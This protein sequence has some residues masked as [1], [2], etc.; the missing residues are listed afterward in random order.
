MSTKT[1]Y[2]L[3]G[4]CGIIALIAT[5]AIY[6]TTDPS[7]NRSLLTN[8]LSWVVGLTSIVLVYAVYL[9]CRESASAISMLALA[10]AVIGNG[11]FLFGTFSPSLYSIGD[12]GENIVLMVSVP[13]FGIGFFMTK[14]MSRILAGIA[15][16]TGI[17]GLA[18]FAVLKMDVGSWS[19]PNNPA[20]L[21]AIM[22]TYLGFVL[23]YVIWMAWTG[24]ALLKAS[25]S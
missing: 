7:G 11:L 2:R 12:I 10:A 19:A 8:L 14:G 9:R 23:C 21:P 18:N 13:L 20:D 3:G 16:L 17:A 24:G 6:F 1:L 5:F 4:I 22:A 25:K 15:I